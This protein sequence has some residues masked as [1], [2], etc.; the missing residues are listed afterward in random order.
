[1][2]RFLTGALVDFRKLAKDSKPSGTK[3]VCKA[4]PFRWRTRS[5]PND[6]MQNLLILLVC[7]LISR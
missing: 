7:T 2:L 5:L 6:T 4:K 1:M 3:T